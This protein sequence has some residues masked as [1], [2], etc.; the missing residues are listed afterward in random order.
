M[1]VKTLT[2]DGIGDNADFDDDND[3]YSDITENLGGS[4][5]KDPSS[6]PDDQDNDFLSD[7]QEDIIGSDPTNPDTDG[8]GVVDGRD[9]NP[10]GGDNSIDPR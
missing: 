8:D 6:I 9:P 10:L 1:R 5:S 3:G 2:A 7:A 4:D